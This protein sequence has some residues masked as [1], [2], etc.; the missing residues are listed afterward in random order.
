MKKLL[1]LLLIPILSFAAEQPSDDELI[2][3]GRELVQKQAAKIEAFRARPGDGAVNLDMNSPSLRKFE[4]SSEAKKDFIDLAT[5]KKK[6]NQV[7]AKKHDLMVF[8]SFSLPDDVIRK[9]SK[10]A[11]EYGAVLVLRGM[12]ENS[13]Q[14][15]KYA[16]FKVNPSG[17]EWDIA[18][19]TFKKFKIDRVPSIVLADATQVSTLENGCAKEGD[20]L[21]VDGEVSIHHAL[22]VMKQYGKGSLAKTAEDILET[23]KN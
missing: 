1:L 9:Y 5:G 16:G 8:I 22:V 10:Q 19:A 17:A 14:K 21:R 13:L 7:G 3:Q 11:A 4:F 23:E 6:L 2:R 12:K 20:Y 18:P 15:T